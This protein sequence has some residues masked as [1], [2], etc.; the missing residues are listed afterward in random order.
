MNQQKIDIVDTNNEQHK[1]IKSPLALYN[2]IA[3]TNDLQDVRGEGNCFYHAVVLGLRSLGYSHMTSNKLRKLIKDE[4]EKLL[5]YDKK[6]GKFNLNV[7][8]NEAFNIY[9]YIKSS[10]PNDIFRNKTQDVTEEDVNEYLIKYINQLDTDTAW[11]LPIDLFTW[12]FYSL[13]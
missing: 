8:F 9:D 1:N 7:M 13:S 11:G 3:V 4:L 6:T 5:E 12:A 10:D 2:Y